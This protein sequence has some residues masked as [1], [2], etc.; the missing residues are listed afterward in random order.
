MLLL[1]AVTSYMTASW[2]VE[3]MAACNALLTV[4][5]RAQQHRIGKILARYMYATY[6]KQPDPPPPPRKIISKKV[7]FG[8]KL[9]YS[10]VRDRDT[11]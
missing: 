10:I 4:E 8:L 11:N 6:V 2:V 3:A 5:E 1:L 7:C 9:Q